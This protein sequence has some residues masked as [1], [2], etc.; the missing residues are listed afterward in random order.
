M[1]NQAITTLRVKAAELEEEAQREV[2][3]SPDVAESNKAADG[4][5]LA[6]NILAHMPIKDGDGDVSIALK[7]LMGSTTFALQLAEVA[8]VPLVAIPGDRL[9]DSDVPTLGDAA[10]TDADNLNLVL[11]PPGHRELSELLPPVVQAELAMMFNRAAMISL[12]KFDAVEPE[13]PEESAAPEASEQ[14]P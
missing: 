1:L 3:G 9:T 10:K 4:L 14:S 5:R 6:A 12:L 7:A 2:S 13:T 8:A 11:L